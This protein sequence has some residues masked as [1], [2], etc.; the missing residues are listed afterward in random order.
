MKQAAAEEVAEMAV[1][2]AA[3]LAIAQPSFT[4]DTQR[5]GGKEAIMAAG[6]AIAFSSGD[7]DGDNSDE[8][9]M[10]TAKSGRGGAKALKGGDKSG[11]IGGKKAW[12]A[13]GEGKGEKGGEALEV[14][15]R[16]RLRNNAYAIVV[17][18][19]GDRCDTMRF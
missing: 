13:A 16:R 9:Q 1:K 2:A 5:R 11:V 15:E 3:T 6:A 19:S 10:T 7:Y 18:A 17:Y 4:A 14:E 12:E 8:W